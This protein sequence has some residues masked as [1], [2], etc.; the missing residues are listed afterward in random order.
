VIDQSKI[1]WTLGTFKPFKSVG[2]D[3]NVLWQQGVEDLVPRLCRMFRACIAYGF[4]LMAWRQVKA[5][6]IPKSQKAAYAKAKAY[7]PISASSFLP[8]TKGIILYAKTSSLIKQIKIV[9]IPF[10]RR[11]NLKGPEEPTLLKKMIQL[12]TKAK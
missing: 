7:W 5:M 12:R 6:F 3:G 2:T 9:I 4:I 10:I 1:R 11:R 8:K